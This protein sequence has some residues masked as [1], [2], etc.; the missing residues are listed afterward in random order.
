MEAATQTAAQGGAEPKLKIDK[1]A[2]GAVMCLKFTGTIDEQ[3][4]GKKLSSTLKGGTLVLDLKDVSKIS[5]FGIREW[6]D[7]VQ[8]VGQKV[9][10]IVLV[11]CAPKVVDQL[12]MVANFAGKGRVFSFYAPYRCDY[13][14]QDARVLLQVDR[15]YEAI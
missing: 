10:S 11:E 3:F 7:F 9:E 8:S 12:N 14:D 13:C 2:E 6:V 5:S 1:F 4:D 15:D